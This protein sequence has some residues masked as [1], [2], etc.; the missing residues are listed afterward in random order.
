[1]LWVVDMGPGQLSVNAVDMPEWDK[2]AQEMYLMIILVMHLL[3]NSTAVTA[4]MD[5][6]TRRV[7][8]QIDTR[9]RDS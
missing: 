8:W 9:Y 2:W 5:K 7:S 6:L 3:P 4:L 1:V